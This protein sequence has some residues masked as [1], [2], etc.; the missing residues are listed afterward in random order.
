M[1]F[2]LAAAD[3]DADTRAV[4]S[5]LIGADYSARAITSLHAT[6]RIQLR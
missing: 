5:E 4:L 1:S 3:A 2:Y 6:T